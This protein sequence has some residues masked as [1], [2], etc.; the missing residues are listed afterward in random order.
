MAQRIRH[1]WVYDEGVRDEGR[2]DDAWQSPR[3]GEPEASTPRRNGEQEH[4]LQGEQHPEGSGRRV[5]RAEENQMIDTA[6][7]EP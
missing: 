5:D 6:H 2:S 3:P 4:P 7:P 1:G